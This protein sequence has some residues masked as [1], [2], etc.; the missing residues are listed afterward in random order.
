MEDLIDE[1]LSERMPPGEDSEAFKQYLRRILYEV[2]YNIDNDTGILIDEI[3]H[4]DEYGIDYNQFEE[5]FL[6]F[7]YGTERALKEIEASLN[8]I[9]EHI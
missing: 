7:V 4:G 1:I 3:R 9:L 6:K 8:R 5:E 2:I